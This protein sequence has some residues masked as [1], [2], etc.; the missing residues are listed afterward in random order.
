MS[1]GYFD[2]AQSRIDD[3]A[4][5]IEDYLYGHELDESDV[6]DLIHDSFGDDDEPTEYAINHHHTMPN[7][8]GYR[9]LTLQELKRAVRNLR[10]AAIY[11]QRA[12]YLLSGDD[13]EEAFRERLRHDLD[14]LA[15]GRKVDF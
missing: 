5:R 4:D 6:Q 3:I 13:S 7:C 15:K 8:F 9:F 14:D 2:Y 12:D 11:A 10:K 1:G